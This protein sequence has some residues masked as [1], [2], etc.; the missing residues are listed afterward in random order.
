MPSLST[1]FTPPL[2]CSNRYAVYIDDHPRHSSTIPPSSGW[3][4][5]SF[6]KCIPS[7][8]FSPM[9][10]EPEFLCTSTITSPMSFLLDPN[11]STTD[12]YT[13][14]A[15][16][17]PPTPPLWIEH[18]QITVQ[19][20]RGDLDLFPEAIASQYS[21]IMGIADS[22]STGDALARAIP[23]LAWPTDTPRPRPAEPGADNS[24]FTA[25]RSIE[26]QPN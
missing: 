16:P 3:V 19:W 2:W 13:T 24:A 23:S 5:P 6:T 25:T 8:G 7:H 11:I 17:E 22:D 9:S 14:I 4:D 26:S 12:L 15:P 20:E 18:D 1:L 10:L 21:K